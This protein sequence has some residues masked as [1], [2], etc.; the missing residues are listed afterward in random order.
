MSEQCFH[1][2]VSYTLLSVNRTPHMS[3]IAAIPRMLT[4]WF[5]AVLANH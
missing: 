2:C 5:D 3:S 4:P 1:H